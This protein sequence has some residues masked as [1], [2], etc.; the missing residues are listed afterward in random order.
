MKTY[1]EMT[2]A[3]AIE[4]IADWSHEAQKCATTEE[5]DYSAEVLVSISEDA[6]ADYGTDRDW[7]VKT[8]SERIM[9][10]SNK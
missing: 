8:L 6:G 3:E 1:S 10:N 7:V 2:T 4:M 9:E 5:A